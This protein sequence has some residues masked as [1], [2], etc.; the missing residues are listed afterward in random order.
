MDADRSSHFLLCSTGSK[1]ASLV[2]VGV[3]EGMDEEWSKGQVEGILCSE[4]LR[5]RVHLV[6]EQGG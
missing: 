4:A 3:A 2:D 5:C 6:L 1:G